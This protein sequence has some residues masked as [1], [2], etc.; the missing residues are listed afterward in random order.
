[1]KFYSLNKILEKNALYNIVFGERSNGKSFAVWEYGIKHYCETGKKMAVIRR[2]QDDFKGKRAPEMTSALVSAGKISKHSKGKWTKT[3]YQGGRWYLAKDDEETGKITSDTEPFAYAFALTAMEHDKSTSYP[4]VDVILFDEFLSRE[5]YLP[6]EF[7]LFMNTLSTIIR[8]RPDVKIF[9][10]GNTVNKWCPY[11]EE[12]GLKHIKNMKQGD[13]DVYTYGD[14]KLTVAVEYAKPNEKGKD[15]DKFFAFDNPKLA[16]ITGGE[17]EMDIYPH[18]PEKYVPKD[19][20]FRYFIEFG[21]EKLQCEIVENSK[22]NFTYI[23]RKTTSFR[24]SDKD[25]IFSPNNKSHYINL[26]NNI[27]KVYDEVGKRIYL[28]FKMDKIFY[29]SNEIGEIV[30]NY[31]MWCRNEG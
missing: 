20:I 1:M 31:L 25:I 12:M 21:G 18:L 16:M 28:Y 11:F 5:G 6:D 15:S 14:S 9:M 3:T 13:I 8:Q 24:H 23:H 2:W 22:G 27:T 26:R 19:V 17:W 29:Q 7:V 30:R 10:L 4:D